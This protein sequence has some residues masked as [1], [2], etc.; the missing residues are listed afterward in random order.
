MTRAA[1]RAHPRMTFEEFQAF[2]AAQPDGERWE[3]VDGQAVMNAWPTDYHQAIVGNVNTFLLNHKNAHGSAW[4]PLPGHGVPVPGV[5]E[6]RAPAPD[7]VVR[8]DALTGQSYSRDP[9]VVFEVLSPSNNKADHDWRF[10]AY[11]SVPSIQQYVVVEQSTIRVA[12][13]NRSENWAERVIDAIDSEVVLDAI[14]VR[15]PLAEIYRWTGFDPG[16][17]P[18]ATRAS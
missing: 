12:V 18:G 6:Q 15:L 7:I 5:P 14:G 3:L 13:M 4:L 8:P 2:V 17:S 16:M 11:S 1:A 9:I 10:M